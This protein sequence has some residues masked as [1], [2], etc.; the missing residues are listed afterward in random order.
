MTKF[1]KL[2]IIILFSIFCFLFSLSAMA[3]KL[4]LN[5]SV[6][7]IGTGQQFKIDLTLDAEGEDINAAEGLISFP[8]EM[9][10]LKEI[11]DGESI[12][13]FWIEKLSLKEAG[14]IKFSGVIPGGFRG[15]LGPYWKGYQPGKVLSLIFNA[16]KE[17]MGAVKIRDAKVLL[18]D[19]QGIPAETIIFNFQFLI[20]NQA[21][22][23]KFQVPSS[24]DTNPP[25]LFTPEVASDPNIFDGKRFLVFAAQDK[26]I[27]VDY[28]AIHE[29]ARTKEAARIDTKDWIVA[30]SPYV[31]KDQ[32]LRS[33]IYV[34]AVDKIGNERFA[35]LPPKFAPWYKK[36]FVD[37]AAGL[38][39]IIVVLFSI[40]L[41]RKYRKISN[42]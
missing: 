35:V 27:G 41:W 18:N 39:I 36:W 2:K 22:S 12:V 1:S 20:S 7:E 16:K 29:S 33:Y 38:G 40:W 10:E 34:K 31:L 23:S 17:G 25:E 11:R 9:L 15:I 5:S 32:K 8:A 19:G 13:S 4:E 42:M 14:K 3:A 24:K 6:S 30:E 21:P 37:T 28:Y 26:G